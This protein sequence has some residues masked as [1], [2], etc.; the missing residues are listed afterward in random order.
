MVVGWSSGSDRSPGSR[1]AAQIT[2][3]TG[4]P[5]RKRL[6]ASSPVDIR[7][8]I[9]YSSGEASG[10]ESPQGSLA[11]TRRY[12]GLVLK[13]LLIAPCDGEDVGEAWVAHQWVSRL[14]ARHEVTLLSYYK[15]GKTPP[16]RQLPGVRV[17]EWTEPPY[18]GGAERLNSMLKP[19]Y[20]PFYLRARRWIRRCASHGG[21]FDLAYQPVPVAM[22][23]P[24]PVAGLGI[25]YIIGPVGGSLSA[26]PGFGAGEDTAPWYV[27]L[28]RLDRLRTRRDPLLRRTYEQASCVI[29]IAPYVKDFLT[30]VTLR[31]FEVMSETGIER[32][33]TAVDRV[34]RKGSVRLLFVGRL[35]RTKGA[36]DAI[37]ALALVRNLPVM[38]DVV[39]DG[40][41]RAEC[42]ALAAQL[43][44]SGRVHFHGWVPRE[45]VSTF[46][47][48]ADI[49]V[50]PSYRE[51]GGNVVFEAM[52]YGLPLIVSDIGGPG[53][54]VDEKS[55]IRLH[56]ESPDQ[57][58]RDIAD[59]I[60]RLVS[61]RPL[62]QSLGEGARR[63][64]TEIGLWDSKIDRLEQIFD[65]ILL[66]NNPLDQGYR[67]AN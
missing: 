56:P 48:S 41:D 31:R 61:D 19:G 37:R 42:E 39:G 27:G 45:L 13:L 10:C 60:E 1:P 40:F 50:F 18:I 24:S 59:A 65:D 33:P 52:G 55:G 3:E 4:K 26:P 5:G 43:G 34:G 36:R 28:R 20:L 66:S 35:V 14:A 29:G 57:Y 32:L 11:A 62:R 67:R 9:S 64:V 58:A 53:A 54:A 12:Y 30:Q 7:L 46:Y 22:R 2:P 51:P 15:Q 38:L 16:S 8:P 49:F 17:V 63:R 23:Y 21:Q 25:P 44:L 47:K 6:S